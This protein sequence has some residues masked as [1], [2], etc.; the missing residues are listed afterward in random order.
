[1]PKIISFSLPEGCKLLDD[2]KKGYSGGT[3]TSTIIRDALKLI[4]E[5]NQ[6]GDVKI[7][8]PKWRQFDKMLSEANDEQFK[9]IEGKV[10][11]L[12]GLIDARKTLRRAMRKYES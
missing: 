6:S 1:M 9:D 3:G 10:K 12:M 11:Q 5:K 4:V 2:A 7:S 8:L